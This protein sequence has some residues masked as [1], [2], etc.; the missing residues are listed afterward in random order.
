M[1]STQEENAAL[2]REFLTTVV[3]GSDTD[4]LGIF[5]SENGGNR[6]PLLES[7]ADCETVGYPYWSAL[8]AA[9]IDITIGDVVATDEDVAVRGIITGAHREPRLN[10]TPARSLFEIA[11]AWF[12]RVKNGQIVETRSIP[13]GPWLVWQLNPPLG[14]T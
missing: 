9:D 13:N 7:K 6:R 1:V 5:L 12:C 4:A 11:I 8:T 3:A 10:Q 14:G 2:V